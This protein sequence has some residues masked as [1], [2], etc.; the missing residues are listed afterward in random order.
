[1]CQ[2]KLSVCSR[3]LLIMYSQLSGIFA[4]QRLDACIKLHTQTANSYMNCNKPVF[5]YILVV[6]QQL[7][8]TV[9]ADVT[10]H[11]DPC[12]FTAA[13]LSGLWE[14]MSLTDPVLECRTEPNKFFRV[15]PECY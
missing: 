11:D 3:V 9:P 12:I 10:S 1:M 8:S 13:Y 5:N 7:F 2:W 15:I 6:S 14:S 4:T